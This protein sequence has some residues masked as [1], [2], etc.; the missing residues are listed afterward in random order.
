MLNFK[1]L[2]VLL[3][4]FML[5]ASISAVSAQV[6]TDLEKFI[7]EG[8]S[9]KIIDPDTNKEVETMGG[10]LI[11]DQNKLYK[12][13]I[14]FKETDTTQFNN[15]ATL[16]YAI[17][18]GITIAS[19]QTGTIDITVND[20]SNTYIVPANYTLTTSGQLSI[21][22]DQSD[23]DFSKL[24]DATQAGF[25]YEFEAKF[26]KETESIK[27]SDTV[28]K[29]IIFEDDIP[30]QA[31]V[32][33]SGSFNSDT[34][35][36]EYT[37]TV[38][39]VKNCT[40]VSVTDTISGEA[41]SING[42]PTFSG[43]SSTPT[44]NYTS[45]GFNYTFPTM[46]D[47][48]VIT[49]T[50]TADVDFLQDS[51]K[52]GVIDQ[53]QANNKVIAKSEDG[54]PH[55]DDS[56]NNI[57]FKTT[58]KS[59]GTVISTTDN[60]D[61]I[62]EW[63]I[64]Y[65]HPTVVSA[66]G[67]TITDV[68]DT[69]SQ[70]YM[71]YYG[72]I[73][74]IVYDKSGN[75]VDNGTISYDSLPTH[76]DSSWTYKI[77]ATDQL[78]SYEFT[79]HTIVDM[80]AINNNGTAQTLV[81][82]AD[83]DETGPDSGSIGIPPSTVFTV[84]KDVESYDTKE[85]HWVSQIAVPA[86][87]LSRFEVVDT[88]PTQWSNILGRRFY[89]GFKNL[90]IDGLNE[91]ENYSVNTN[92]TS[93]VV[94][95]FY[96]D[97]AQTIAGINGG[98][99]GRTITLHITTTVD[100]DWLQEGYD[101]A[102]Y[103]MEH[104]NEIIVNDTYSDK[105]K[106]IFSEPK[107]QKT[108][109]Y[110]KITETTSYWPEVITKD[111]YY[112]RYEVLLS[113]NV[114]APLTVTDTFDTNILKVADH[115]QSG[116][117]QMVIYGGDQYNQDKGPSSVSYTDTTDGITL[118][119][120][121]I[122]MQDDGTP[123]S[124]YRIYYYLQLKDGIDLHEYVLANQGVVKNTAKWGDFDSTYEYKGEYEAF[125]K[126]IETGYPQGR[127]VKYI[128]DYNPEAVQLNNGKNITL[129]DLLDK[130][131][132]LRYNTVTVT[133]E[134]E[135]NTPLVKWNIGGTSAED[136]TD[137]SGGTKAVFTIPDE[138]HV[139]ITYEAKV[140][141]NGYVAFNNYATTVKYSDEVKETGTFSDADDGGGDAAVGHLVI[142]KVNGY[143]G[144][145][146][147]PGL[148][149][150]V[151]PQKTDN[152]TK[153]DWKGK[154][155][156]AADKEKDY[157]IITTD[158]D[159]VLNISGNDYQIYFNQ[160]YYLQ[161][162][163]IPEGYAT[164]TFNYQFTLK[165][166]WADVNYDQYIYF[167][168]DSFQIK[169]WPIEG[170]IVEKKVNSDATTDLT[171]TYNFRIT[172]LNSAGEIQTT[173][174]NTYGTDTFTNGQLSFTLSNNEQKTFT[175]F[176]Q[177]QKLLIEELGDDNNP[178][179]GYVVTVNDGTN[180]TVGSSFIGQT[181]ESNPKLTFTNT[182]STEVSAAK[183]WKNADNSTTA[184]T[185]ASVIFTLYA[186][187]YP[188]EYTVTLDG[189]VDTRP[190]DAGGYE[191]SSWTAK[192]VNLPKLNESGQAIT[193]TIAETTTYS[194]YTVSP[195]TPV[196]D[197]GTITNSKGQPITGNISLSATKSI[198][199]WPAD[200]RKFT[201]NLSGSGDAADKLNDVE[202]S[203]QAQKDSRT[204][205]FGPITFNESDVDNNF[206]FTI[207][208]EYPG[209]DHS[210]YIY[211][212]VT[213][214]SHNYTAIVTPKLTGDVI[215]FDVTTGG[216]TT[217]HASGETVSVGTITN[218][219]NAS[220]TATIY[221]QKA[222]GSGSEWP[223]NK[224]KVRFTLSADTEKNTGVTD[225]PMPSVNYTE[226][227]KTERNGSIGPINYSSSDAGKT[228]YY[229]LTEDGFGD[230]WLKNDPIPVTVTV[231]EDTGSGTLETTVNYPSGQKFFTITN[232]KISDT[233]VTLSGTKH[234]E[235][236]TLENQKWNFTIKPHQDTPTAPL[237]CNST[238]SCTVQNEGSSI[239]FGSIKFDYTHLD[240]TDPKTQIVYKYQLTEAK[241]T[242]GSPDHVILDPNASGSNEKEFTITVSLDG[243]SIKAV[244][245]NAE[246]QEIKP[247]DTVYNVETFTNTYVAP[248]SVE[249]EAT[250]SMNVWPKDKQFNITMK[251]DND[252]AR[253]KLSGY[254]DYTITQQVHKDDA[255]AKFGPISF[256][257]DDAGADNE[258]KF[259]ISELNDQFK[260]VTYS[261][262]S[263]TVYLKPVAGTGGTLS[264]Q[265]KIGETGT[266]QTA[267]SA[268][269]LGTDG[270][271][272]T[273]RFE[274]S[275]SVQFSGKKT[276][277]GKS[278][279]TAGQFTF[280]ITGPNNYI[281]TCTNDASGNIN[282]PVIN[283]T[284]GDIGQTYT[285]TITED[286]TGVDSMTHK[287]DG[288]EYS[289]TSHTVSVKIVDNGDGTI[290]AEPSTNYTQLNFVNTYTASGT[291]TI[292][293][294][295]VLTGGNWPDEKPVVFTLSADDNIPMPTETTKTLTKTGTVSF[296]P[297]SYKLE[298]AGK[299]YTYTIE[300]TTDLGSEWAKSGSI[301]ATVQ[302]GADNGDGTL[303]ESTVTYDP[304]DQTITNHKI[305]PTSVVISGTKALT[306]NVQITDQMKWNFTLRPDPDVQQTNVP[307]PTGIG[308][309][310]TSCTV[311]NTL[312]S[313]EFGPIS[314]T[315]NDLAAGQAAN[316][317]YY[318]ITESK[319]TDEPKSPDYIDLDSN[320]TR[321]FSITVSLDPDTKNI[322]AV[323]NGPNGDIINPDATSGKYNTV[324][325]TN[326][327]VA[328][329]VIKFTATKDIK[330]EVNSAWP[331]NKTFEFVLAADETVANNAASDKLNAI[332][333]QKTLKQD[334]KNGKR[335]A[336]FPELHFTKADVDAGKVFAFKI[337]ETGSGTTA[338]GIK[339]P[340]ANFKHTIVITPYQTADNKVGI[341]ASID[342]RTEQVISGNTLDAGTFT[343][344]YTASGSL[345]LK[346]T[347]SIN[348]WPDG[349]PWPDGKFFTFKIEDISEYPTSKIQPNQDTATTSS[350]DLSAIFAPI[351]FNQNDIGKTFKFKVSEQEGDLN[352]VTYDTQTNYTV[353]VKV[354]DKGDGTLSF[355]DANDA[356]LTAGT[357]TNPLNVGTFTNTYNASGTLELK[358]RKMVVNEDSQT[359]ETHTF[360]FTMRHK[361]ESAESATLRTLKGQ[362]TTNNDNQYV[363]FKMYD[364]T[365]GTPQPISFDLELLD[366]LEKTQPQHAIPVEGADKPT[367]LI[368]YV[369]EEDTDANAQ[370]HI[371][372]DIDI[373]HNHLPVQVK[374]VDNGDGTLT[375]TP[376]T[377]TTDGSFDIEKLSFV[378]HEIHEGSYP[379]K[380]KKNLSGK[381]ALSD[382]DKWLFTLEAVPNDTG[383]KGPLPDACQSDTTKPCTV[384]N[385]AA[386][387]FS[388]DPIHFTYERLG[389]DHGTKK[390]KYKVTE[391]RKTGV[392]YAGVTDDVS[393][394]REFTLTVSATT[395]SDG[396]ENVTVTSDKDSLDGGL[397]GYL[398]FNNTYQ[399]SGTAKL[400]VTKTMAHNYWPKD[401][402]TGKDA[403]FTFTIEEDRNNQKSKLT[404]SKTVT[405]SDKNNPV[406]TF[407]D[408]TF[409]QSDLEYTYKFTI[410]ENASGIEGLDDSDE[411]YTVTI[412]PIADG[413]SIRPNA[414]ITKNKSDKNYPKTITPQ[415]VDGS[416]AIGVGSFTNSYNVSGI[417]K[418]SATKSINVWPQKKDAPE[419]T[420]TFQ[421]EDGATGQN[422]I[423]TASDANKKTVKR[424]APTAIFSDI[425]FG[426]EDINKIFY[427]KI[428]EINNNIPGV[429]YSKATERIVKV[430]V[431]DNGN[432]TLNF[433]VTDEKDN[434]LKN[435][436]GVYDAGT[437]INS[438]SASGYIDLQGRKY[439]EDT[440]GKAQERVFSY[441]LRYKNSQ[442]SVAAGQI[443]I[444]DGEKEQNGENKKF[445][446][447]RINYTIE[448]LEAENSKATRLETDVPTWEIV[449]T[450]TEDVTEISQDAEIEF[451]TH[452]V[453]ITVRIEDQG[454]GNLLCT[455]SPTVDQI[456]YTNHEVK[457]DALTISGKKNFEGR[458][459]GS[460]ETWNFKLTAIDE[461]GNPI[462]GAPMPVSETCPQGSS[463]CTVSN[464]GNTFSFGTIHFTK[465][466]LP[467]DHTK[468]KV[469]T[470]K[471][472]EIQPETGKNPG[473]SILGEPSKTFT[474]TVALGAD[475]NIKVTKSVDDLTSYLTFTNKYE[476]SGSIRLSAKKLVSGN[477]P[478]KFTL[479][480]QAAEGAQ[481]APRK[482]AEL[483]EEQRALLSQQAG[484]DETVNFPVLSFN[485]SDCDKDFTFVIDEVPGTDPNTI[486]SDAKYTV[487]ITPRDNG[488]GTITPE[489]KV[490]NAKKDADKGTDGVYILK[491][492]AL[493]FTNR[494]IMPARLILQA[495]KTMKNDNWPTGGQTFTFKLGP[496]VT[497]GNAEAKLNALSDAE[498]RGLT[499]TADIYRQ[500]VEFTELDFTLAD[501]DK[502][503][504][505][506][507][508]EDSENGY[509][510]ITYTEKEYV[511]RVVPSIGD[512]NEIA[513]DISINNQQVSDKDIRK[514]I[515][516]VYILMENVCS[517]ENE[518]TTEVQ[519]TLKSSKR[520]IDKDGIKTESHDLPFELWHIDDYT[521]YKAGDQT[522]KPIITRTVNVVDGA[523]PQEFD[524][525][526]SFTTEP[527]SEP[528]EGLE[529]LP[530]MV[531]AGKATPSM[532]GNNKLWTVNYVMDEKT[533][534]DR[535][536]KPPEQTY[537]IQV[538]IED[539][540]Q[541]KLFVKS[542][543]YRD[544]RDT[545]YTLVTGT[546]DDGLDFS[547]GTF[548]NTERTNS[549]PLT[550]T[551][552]KVLN[553]R[554]L[555]NTDLNKWSFTLEAV[556]DKD[557]NK[558]PQPEKL[559][560]VNVMNDDKTIGYSFE[561]IT[562]TPQQLGPC[563]MTGSTYTC[564]S[565]EYTYRITETG[566][567][568]GV[569]NDEAK[570][571][572]VIVSLIE[573]PGE[574]YGN[575]QVKT[576]PENLN[577]LLTALTFTN[578]YDA[579]GQLSLNVTKKML[580]NWPA[581]VNSF[582][583]SIE[584][585]TPEAK[586]KLSGST[587]LE[588]TSS[589]QTLPFGPFSFKLE[590]KGKPFS[591]IIKEDVPAGA[592]D[593][594]YEGVRYD[595]TKYRLVITPVDGGSGKLAFDYQIL[596]ADTGGP[597]TEEYNVPSGTVITLQSFT[598]AY[599]EVSVQFKGHKTLEDYPAG[600][601]APVFTYVLSEN[602][603]ELQQKTTTGSG[604]FSFDTISYTEPCVHT[605]QITETAGNEKGI[606]YDTNKYTAV[607]TITE[608][609]KLLEKS[610]VITDAKGNTVSED[611]LDFTNKYS[612]V[613]VQ[614]G[615]HKT[616][617]GRK[618][619]NA[620]FSFRLLDA[621]GN[622][623]ELVRNNGAGYFSFSPIYFTEDQIGTYTY[624]VRETAGSEDGMIYDETEYHIS[625][626]VSKNIF[627]E[628]IMEAS[629]E[630]GTPLDALNFENEYHIVFY[631]ITPG[632]PTLPETG[633][634]AVRPQAL[635]EKPLSVN[636][637]PLS[638]TL[639]IPTLDVIT[640]IVEVPSQ[641]GTYPVTWLGYD[642]GLLE[643]YAMPGEGP[644]VITG[645]NH[646]NTTEAGP[647][648]LIQQM[649]IGDR[650]FVTDENNE[651]QI[652][653]VYA[654]EKIDETDF[655]GLNRI[656]ES[657]ENSL[658]MLTCEDER[659]NGG[660]QNRRI[661]AA[662]PVNGK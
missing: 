491:D 326:T 553:G 226:L 7:N 298:D 582:T 222:L 372:A 584:G 117:N 456:L 129:T 407:A 486:Y 371:D 96:K 566:T 496:G 145:I 13:Q 574:N 253:S 330:D 402:K 323:V 160:I 467:D 184:P 197:Q 644:T 439:V 99:S 608:N 329:G 588:F 33:K 75:Q 541:G 304:Q 47:G 623:L 624:T 46:Q 387:D 6:T 34:G 544:L 12:V 351:Q 631:R 451:D 93:K 404:G 530:D 472:E 127:V 299:K 138:T 37:I 232:T 531:E 22:F 405:I 277:N 528:V 502:E 385:N 1:K 86:G 303:T 449:Y 194:D 478:D 334:V 203:L 243:S 332:T 97:K 204:V 40:N 364:Y 252:L 101:L 422:K 657:R 73:D 49:I 603:K 195:S 561:T 265:Y 479:R 447:N 125:D 67:N 169:N 81:N 239:P 618:L 208:E 2:F 622:L 504:R 524:Y 605:Y 408:I 543:R 288:I 123:Y 394:I 414:V 206:T 477:T 276:L 352:Y 328:E 659:P 361:D 176:Q 411:S 458:Q 250:K 598:N 315:A 596:D 515:S 646:L 464:N 251:A 72:D 476:A 25:R 19:Q 484:K 48:E 366:Q 175:G 517:F 474:V 322:K 497:G 661:I 358:A 345:Y 318:Q 264:I 71:K 275:T 224:E 257:V 616:L 428:T 492:G 296:G 554:A 309:D 438:Y 343:N 130:K 619:E 660:Y 539:N 273:N 485:I 98:D 583:V 463:S 545:E 520:I 220:S 118:T 35:K 519:L 395:T 536:L 157:A 113:G 153:M 392:D 201:F 64:T 179:T 494:Y 568:D 581:H 217:N 471:V 267:P 92:D 293:I 578:K 3:L 41:L 20:G 314:F 522:V 190:T 63:K 59:D 454:N 370:A 475:E 163:D 286:Q 227:S 302:V 433:T 305:Q 65:N 292:E 180:T 613:S 636:Y 359:A 249:I 128:I 260:N 90:I 4:A 396:H 386:G 200:N 238:T 290:K 28:T 399:A 638:W 214:D 31:Y 563:S 416:Y 287:K 198:T 355:T 587:K 549:T 441:T 602:G 139:H 82:T 564:A 69:A 87:N 154:N 331:K 103:M 516:R 374:I 466:S 421:I 263:Y 589:G 599:N 84:S 434:P 321:K 319:K 443:T 490:N 317:Y 325:Y 333:D 151:Y 363:E 225:V 192:F 110:Q 514:P 144:S 429:D 470:Y 507:I 649:E 221:V 525:P 262:N 116:W 186:N 215:T 172:I 570:T 230:G 5:F 628:L 655:A 573:E 240:K 642:A 592:I 191:S 521:K 236:Q 300:E 282:C 473:W 357:E 119:A 645:H 406:G 354:V 508:T 367:W 546:G 105:T 445:T 349:K 235:G 534:V 53:S 146:K 55:Q 310:S 376:I 32:T 344:E 641:D 60:G 398:T 575:I 141:G 74:Y 21:I 9:V 183:A 397:T 270:I 604:D 643:G 165:E 413:A 390:Y 114:T 297:I 312:G 360:H 245:K 271:A 493:E 362:V 255:T 308:C 591:Y 533:V 188:T 384:E 258:Y 27:F 542:L 480:M 481:N 432:G 654:N 353:T 577:D 301:T 15:T 430:L 242:S 453:D 424:T 150:K 580:G 280:N 640:E 52:D 244:V 489:V 401:A 510:Y 177:H 555:T 158:S 307:M 499:K 149:F 465:A 182:P 648:A 30:G 462:S 24:A 356:P 632:V 503:F 136:G 498:K 629:E 601:T 375:C 324:S 237:P 121:T 278:S 152:A 556:A 350:T 415:L 505:F 66:G 377:N 527:L 339:Y 43:N 320:R 108:G 459:P 627:G 368:N 231:G 393:L 379:I 365:N 506:L 281:N 558:G 279:M 383:E 400:S 316:T 572:K 229:Q 256:T 120:N 501:A 283:Y 132:T 50:Y 526:I 442:D 211:Q 647:F 483:T 126:Y 552:K 609:N 446:L 567:V 166:D 174:N 16:T 193:Y 218:T 460:D 115:T 538:E 107:I 78:Y 187:G 79:Y 550:I 266:Y 440:D 219:Y 586:A 112:F 662:A 246:G 425:S 625:V 58:D 140:V 54:D 137:Y 156:D 482:L 412:T 135:E 607:V 569:T 327:P 658:T 259:I 207:K 468:S 189:I 523:T 500:T 639:Q 420:F 565:K 85:V 205:T 313:F 431:G 369:I 173:N 469:Y 233:T 457:E 274:A 380:G 373:D 161:E 614:F 617:S 216:T 488:D 295:K 633:F 409:N 147:L 202:K 378:N 247:T 284:Q 656:V 14:R 248:G 124:Y 39:A 171:K 461:N 509:S 562:F 403:A 162:L 106:V 547:V 585:E 436:D 57:P 571:F 17:P 89:D 621:E 381:P 626:K 234:L 336:E 11:I 29:N 167:R 196:S 611:K 102:N 77:P 535:E 168:D 38:S 448:D 268:I 164:P 512:N 348:R 388:F 452:A 597:F 62:V 634:S 223:T 199:T 70:A 551:G 346:A 131:L 272:F 389:P 419:T 88:L 437:L 650:I 590:D 36:M 133:T 95:T 143:D 423:Y 100:P 560:A 18:Q 289:Q 76:S 341:R 68:I 80:T 285:Y 170:L 178:I 148:K 529:S 594:R 212:G 111:F 269:K 557:G 228:Y 335:T 610:V 134:P 630:S 155:P 337:T 651:I 417:L 427:F 444:K 410:K 487:V 435:N 10:K 391:S 261:T 537:E 635:P 294:T 615:G 213:Y 653:Q 495:T 426:R 109:S 104:E 83:S 548:E 513:L 338:E 122:P 61:K 254:K 181:D 94:I 579:D 185:D 209:T 159:G 311:T 45:T 511:V 418:L 532:D 652:F 455:Q 306:G 347:K 540:G 606:V 8:S 56:Y 518:Y 26:N 51:N 91:E 291:A 241:A 595:L 620:E 42:K 44:G 382:T 600:Q 23:E 142:T 340:E 450:L 593:G 612:T 637:K 559:T 210:S 342:G 576:V